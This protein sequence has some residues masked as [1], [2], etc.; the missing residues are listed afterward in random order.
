MT[1]VTN[2]AFK[3]YDIRG[4]VPSEVNEVMAYRVGR[5]FVERYNAKTVVVGRDIRPTSESLSA[6]LARGICDAGADVI[7]IGLCGTEMVYFAT[8]FTKA[9]GG[10]MVTA[11]HNPHDYNGMK[12]VREGARPISADTGLVE[13]GEQV[14]N[15]A[16][17]EG[18]V[19]GKTLG[20]VQQLDVMPDYIACITK[21]IDFSALKPLKV[22]VNAGNGCAGP[23]LDEL[24]KLLPFEFIR[25]NHEPDGT[26][27]NGIPNPLL[28]P[29]REATASIVKREK[30]DL[31]IA[32]DG[33]YDR[34]FLFD[35]NGEFIEG[36]YLVGFL[37]EAFLNKFPGEKIMYDPRLTW[38]TL[39]IVEK[40]KGTS[41]ISK[42]GHAFMKECMR[43]NNVLYGGE[44][45]AH[46][47]F[48]DFTCCDSGMIPWLVVTEHMSK[49]GASLSSLV[50]ARI[51]KFPCSGEINRK[52]DDSKVVIEKL[53]EIYTAKSGKIDFLD[54]IS[55]EFAQWRFN[56]RSSNTEPV[57]RLNIETRG[58]KALLAEKTEELL[59][60]IGGQEA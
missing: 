13:I 6:A 20:K 52:V 31:G 1:K 8:D 41:V 17:V 28:L 46:H 60:I 38:N 7:D 54:G 3:A 26:F 16:G 37:A 22:V 23:A 19:A 35:E 33:D 5:V 12:L 58:D 15:F 43:K 47:Y 25:V 9:S 18:L 32:W 56:V 2:V 24:A 48:R 39:E 11:S 42:S 53:K 49:T 14:V 57:I 30:A 50:Q 4:R 27:P 10:I 45:S 40:L 21:D 44:M 51:D 34:C 59:M 36:Y 55:V 29:N